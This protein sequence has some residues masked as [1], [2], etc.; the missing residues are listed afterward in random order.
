MNKLAN[1]SLYFTFIIRKQISHK[2][3]DSS[4]VPNTA[5]NAKDHGNAPRRFAR[6][7]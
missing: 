2:V 1:S 7:G 6:V 5:Y 4:T 3:S